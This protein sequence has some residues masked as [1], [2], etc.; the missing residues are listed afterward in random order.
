MTL[1]AEPKT[2][3]LVQVVYLGCDLRKQDRR[4]G[5]SETGKENKLIAD[6]VDDV[7]AIALLPTV[8]PDPSLCVICSH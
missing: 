3:P 4:H 8:C 1:R 5:E 2:R 7:T 6:G